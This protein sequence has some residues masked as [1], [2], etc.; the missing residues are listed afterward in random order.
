MAGVKLQVEGRP[1]FHIESDKPRD[2]SLIPLTLTIDAPAVISV[3]GSRSRLRRTS[4]SRAAISRSRC[5]G[6]VPDRS[7]AGHREGSRGRRDYDS[8]ASALPGLRRDH[9]LQAN[10]D[11]RDLDAQH[12]RGRWML[13]GRGETPAP[14]TDPTKTS[15]APAEA[16][17]A[18][19]VP[20]A[21]TSPPDQLQLFDQFVILGTVG[22][23]LDTAEF[24]KFISDAERG[25]KSKDC[26]RAED[27]WRSWRSSFFG[28]LAL[29]LTPCVLPMIPVNLAI[30]GA[31]AQRS[32]HAA[33]SCSG[34]STAGDGARLRRARGDRHPTAGT[35]GAMNSSPW[36]NLGIA[37]LF[38]VL[39]ARDVRRDH[40]GLH[41]VPERPSPGRHR[42]EA[43]CGWHSPWAPSPHSSPAPASRRW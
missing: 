17:G 39:G 12:R 40:G 25:V 33:G 19:A 21:P 9:L 13:A 29:N 8:G 23:Y 18:S 5:R 27:R 31:G 11:P 24:L 28:G 14:S 7:A 37:A 42:S 3:D 1:V 35:F 15:S 6:G 36:F 41:A 16:P 4:R 10:D 22:G 32:K 38:V 30:I 34:P 2:P 20:A 43:H 26:S